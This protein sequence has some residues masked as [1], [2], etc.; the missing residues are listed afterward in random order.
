MAIA[1]FCAVWRGGCGSVARSPLPWMKPEITA[2]WFNN[3][4]SDR[5]VRG[6]VTGVPRSFVK[7]CPHYN[8]CMFNPFYFSP[9]VSVEARPCSVRSVVFMHSMNV[10][11]EWRSRY[12]CHHRCKISGMMGTGRLTPLCEVGWLCNPSG[13]PSPLRRDGVLH[14]VW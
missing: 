4:T 10:A 8:L 7:L 5:N 11:A 3:H 1:P 9:L 6:W 2:D 13:A 12:H 14:T